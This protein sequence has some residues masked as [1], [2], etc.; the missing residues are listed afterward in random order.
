M[1]FNSGF[2]GLIVH[3]CSLWYSNSLQVAVLSLLSKCTRGPPAENENT[4]GCVHV[5]L[6]PLTFWRRADDAGNT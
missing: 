2:K 3:V 4:R 5:Q 1:G 6:T